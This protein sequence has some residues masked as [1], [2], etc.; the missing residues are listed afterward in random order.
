M[1]PLLLFTSVTSPAVCD[2][3]PLLILIVFHEVRNPLLSGFTPL[4]HPP[5][6]PSV[7]PF[8]PPLFPPSLLSP[9]SPLRPLCGNFWPPDGNTG[10]GNLT[11]RPAGN[12]ERSRRRRLLGQGGAH[13]RQL[14]GQGVHLRQLLGHLCTSSFASGSDYI[15]QY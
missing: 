7:P 15:P 1:P 2:S 5:F 13:L 4:R 6:P 3:I 11:S 14:L 9:C 12:L 8:P 10:V